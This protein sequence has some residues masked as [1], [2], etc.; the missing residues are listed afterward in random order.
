[1]QE[2][3]DYDLVKKCKCKRIYQKIIFIK[4]KKG[5]MVYAHYAKVVGNNIGINAMMKIEIG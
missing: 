5:M 1:M 3:F 2:L 4:D